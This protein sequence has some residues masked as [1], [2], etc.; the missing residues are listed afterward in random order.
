MRITRKKGKGIRIEHNKKLFWIIIVL[1]AVLILLIYFIVHKQEK[2]GISINTDK[3]E[4]KIGETIKIT[5]KNNLESAIVPTILSDPEHKKIFG[6]SY[7]IG[8]IEKFEDGKWI[9]IEPVWR[10]EN[11]CFSE[12]MYNHAIESHEKRVF[13]W[14]QTILICNK[15]DRMERVEYAE[16]GKYRIS[17]N[18]WTKEKQA[19][20]TIYSN[21]FIIKDREKSEKECTKDSDCVPATCCHPDSCTIKEKA[22]DCKNIMCSMVC[23][24]PLDCAA[25]YCGCVEGKCEVINKGE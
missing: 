9:G 5:I 17:S 1:L 11:S 21:E 18:V 14:N 2:I 15:E 3:T 13:E 16:T 4:Y 12:C 7:G 6:E 22:P 23:S 24:G 25:G 20:E 10:C 19:Y 8:M